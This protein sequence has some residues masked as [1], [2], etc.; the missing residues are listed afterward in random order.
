M[1]AIVATLVH[2]SQPAQRTRHIEREYADAL[3]NELSAQVHDG[4]WQPVGGHFAGTTHELAE[5]S[6]FP[7]MGHTIA[8]HL[9]NRSAVKS[10]NMMTRMRAKPEPRRN[11]YPVR[12]IKYQDPRVGKNVRIVK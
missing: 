7:T 3:K 12:G 1:Y 9:W 11:P 8:E 5:Q 6:S 10:Q 2:S 4:L